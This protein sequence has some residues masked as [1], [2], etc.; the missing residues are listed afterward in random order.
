MGKVGRAVAGV[1]AS[2]AIATGAYTGDVLITNAERNAVAECGREFEGNA[3]ANCVI[4]AKDAYQVGSLLNF[5]KL[6]GAVG[7]TGCG[8][9]GYKAVKQE[10]GGK[11]IIDDYA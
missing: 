3:E 6:V 10:N 5:L 2:A 4:D 8:Y 7:I 1:A 9:L 11:G